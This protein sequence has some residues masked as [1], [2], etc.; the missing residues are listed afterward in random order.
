MRVPIIRSLSILVLLTSAAHAAPTGWSGVRDAADTLPRLHALLV[1]HDAEPV[2][3]HVRR[4]PG[5]D[6]PAPLKSLSKTVLSAVAGIAIEQG[7]IAGLD[8]PLL[9]LLGPAP[10]GADPRVR[11]IT[12]GHALSLRTGLRSTS[13]RY[14]G[15]WV[16][17][18]D[19]V[20]HVLTRPMVD[21]PGGEMIY[22]TGSTHLV[23]AA[24][25]AT[26]DSVFEQARAGLA[27]PLDI[28]LP[29]WIT[30]PQGVHFGGND[31][32]LSPRALARFGELYRNGG[33]HDGRQVL[34][35]DWIRKSWTAY[36][37]SP[38]SGDDYGYGWFITE[39]ADEQVYYGRGYGG[40]ALFVVP[41]VDL[42]L[43][44]TSDPNPPSNGGYFGA[45][46]E[47]ASRA[48]RIA[49][50]GRRSVEAEAPSGVDLPEP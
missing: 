32:Q 26:G 33:Q 47:I 16:Q 23:A 37:T 11:E 14:Y 29:D 9:E 19:W 34:P 42:T 20:D 7:R 10:D 13:G 30:D 45:I 50:T 40:Q 28:R 38:W 2:I 46:K 39:L 17:S 49:K 36:G 24:L 8:Q 21:R 12:L 27:Q 15:A 44:M 1:L 5:L 43:V 31:M 4:G 48:I 41:S 3:E 6:R 35:P 18:D 25:A 22:S